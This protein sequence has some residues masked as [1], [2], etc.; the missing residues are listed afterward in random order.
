MSRGSPPGKQ[1]KTL[2]VGVFEPLPKG[3]D[4]GLQ[5]RR[6][7]KRG[8]GRRGKGIQLERKE[9]RE[10]RGYILHARGICINLSWGGRA[11]LRGWKKVGSTSRWGK[12]LT[13]EKI[14]LSLMGG[15]GSCPFL[16]QLRRARDGKRG[17]L[18]KERFDP[19]REPPIW[20]GKGSLK[21]KNKGQRVQRKGNIKACRGRG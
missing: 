12:Y 6:N 1:R 16:L 17:G 8:G 15:E 11:F 9:N 4:L 5:E 18:S 13:M 2:G 7:L 20:G 14:P 19:S 21:A 10:R 3:K